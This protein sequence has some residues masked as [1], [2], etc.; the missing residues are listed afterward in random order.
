MSYTINPIGFS[1]NGEPVDNS[2]TE[3]YNAWDFFSGDAM[4]GFLTAD[5]AHAWGEKNYKGPD[6]D[7]IDL[8]WEVAEHSAT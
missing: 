4:Q 7:G 6:V 1:I 5:E 3:G 2:E 8:D